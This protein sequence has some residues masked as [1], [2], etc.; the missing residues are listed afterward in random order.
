[1]KK[2]VVFMLVIVLITMA[3]VSCS[4]STKTT[5]DQNTQ[6]SGTSSTETVKKPSGETKVI[7]AIA[8]LGPTKKYFKIP[9]E[10]AAEVER[11]SNGLL[12]IELLG[13]DEVIPE[14]EQLY[15]MKKG[16]VDMMFDL[17]TLS[18]LCPLY[19]A[20]SLTGMTTWEER[21]AGLYDLYQEVY[22][23]EGGVKWLGKASQPQWWVLA[24]N[25]PVPTL[26]S[27]KGMKIRCNQP[28]SPV[29]KALGAVPTIIPYGDIYQA[30]ERKVIDGFI[31][32]PEDWVQNGWQEVSS[33]LVNLRLLEGG[34]TGILMNLDVWNSLTEEQQSWLQ[35]PLIDMERMFYAL[36]YWNQASGEHEI[37]EAGL[38][39]VNWTKEEKERA[40]QAVRE[41]MWQSYKGDIDPEV[42]KRFAEIVG[43]PY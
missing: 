12:K 18:Q 41:N 1:M 23:R 9:E 27:L 34:Q 22:E 33:Y 29:I 28:T 15:A 43:L 4:S 7:K 3:F 6:S 25:K 11:R 40:L 31:M 36:C 39:L 8:C 14:E 20:M 32:T 38:E 17:E 10:Y 13:G 37:L 26:D 24:T 35:D 5:T 19:P 21:E 30:M 2:C 16:I 42:A